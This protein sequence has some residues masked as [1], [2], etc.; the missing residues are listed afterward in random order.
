MNLK[1]H[2]LGGRELLGAYRKRELSPVEVTQA[3]LARRRRPGM[4]RC[5]S[6]PTLVARCDCRPAGAGFSASSRAWAA[7][8]LTRLTPA[9]WPAR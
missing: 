2:N 3:V 9:G 6:A 4:A 7:S 8:R 1:L 5:T